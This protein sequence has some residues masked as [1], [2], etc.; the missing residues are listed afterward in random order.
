PTGHETAAW[1][2]RLLGHSFI[3]DDGLDERA[4]VRE[5]YFKGRRQSRG[6]M[7]TIAPTVNCNFGCSYCFQEHPARS[8]TPDHD[9]RI[10]DFVDRQLEEDSSLS[11]TWFGGE[12]LMGF[13]TILEL[14]PYLGDLAKQRRC[15]F[16]QAIITNGYL[17]NARRVD[18]LA[19]LGRFSYVQIT[20]DGP[21]QLHD[22]RRALRDGRPTFGRIL[23][24]IVGAA[25]KLPVV[26][27]VNVDRS[28][29]HGLEELVDLLAEAGLVGRV[30]VY[31]GHTLPYTDV[32]ADVED[33]AFSRAEFA[34]L[35]VRFKFLLLQRGWRRHF[36]LPCPG[37]GASCTADSPGG[38]VLA[39]GDLVFQCW[40]EVA[41]SSDQASGHLDADQV[42]EAM[43]QRRDGW[44]EFDPFTHE[45]CRTCRVQPLCRGGCAWE[46]RK[47]DAS[48]PGHCTTFRF[49]IEDTLRLYHLQL[50]LEAGLKEVAGFGTGGFVPA[51]RGAT[52]G[53]QRRMH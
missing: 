30:G 45:P 21:P 35:E 46:A 40:N 41:M 38:Y 5:R 4:V 39:P 31:L 26:V 24:N 52:A 29:A 10:R 1:A 9:A 37:Y 13:R 15:G 53:P 42:T 11:V 14:A 19:G 49:N 43:R 34:A 36:R 17:L 23:D 2:R 32:C 44:K 50:V 51:E 47:N 6:L 7:L 8:M 48:E 22:R 18:Q 25:A 16:S 27:R 3:V 28:N 20:L 12:P 33:R